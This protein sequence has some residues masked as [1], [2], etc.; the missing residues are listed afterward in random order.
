MATPRTRIPKLRR[1]T[2]DGGDSLRMR[3]EAGLVGGVG[4]SVVVGDND[5]GEDGCSFMSAL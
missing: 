5:A 1:T 2:D 4:S 3:I